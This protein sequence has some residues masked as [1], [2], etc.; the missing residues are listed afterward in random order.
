[1]L[2]EGRLTLAFGSECTA[3]HGREGVAAGGLLSTADQDTGPGYNPP[4]PSLRDLPLPADFLK[5][6][7]S[8]RAKAQPDEPVG[9]MLDSNHD[10]V[11]DCTIPTDSHTC[12]LSS[13]VVVRR[14]KWVCL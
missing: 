13:F 8:W 12:V 14:E 3:H 4:K 5:R 6:T 7:I 10:M 1:M 2:L 11:V 9:A